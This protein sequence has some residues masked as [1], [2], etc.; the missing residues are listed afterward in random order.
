MSQLIVG[1]TGGIGSGKTAVTRLFAN[2]GAAIVDTDVIAHTLTSPNGAAIPLI[3]QT[4]GDQ[5]ITTDMALD[6]SAM[7][8]IVFS[9][10]SARAKLEN[11]LHPMILAQASQEID[12]AADNHASY[13]VLVV[14]LLVE[15][16][17]FSNFVDRIL[18]IDCPEALQ[19]SRVKERNGLAEDEIKKI[20]ATQ[21]DRATRLKVADDIL[22]NSGTL[23]D[24]APRVALLDEKYRTLARSKNAAYDSKNVAKN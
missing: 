15:R 16:G 8:K 2:L 19:I 24:L 23:G 13:V 17:N 12:G 10:S 22:E 7:R 11:I 3:R 1:L 18:V 21:A 5:V 6:R 20:I 4:F 9:N 14:P